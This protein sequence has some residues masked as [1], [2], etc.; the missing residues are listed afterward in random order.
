[1]TTTFMVMTSGL[2]E[3]SSSSF[4][5]IAMASRARSVKCTWNPARATG[6]CC[7]TSGMS[8]ASVS[9]SARRRHCS[10]L[11]RPS[12]VVTVMMVMAISISDICSEDARYKISCGRGWWSTSVLERRSISADESCNVGLLPRGEWAQVQHPQSMSCVISLVCRQLCSNLA[13]QEPLLRTR[14]NMVAGALDLLRRRGLGKVEAR[15]LSSRNPGAH[16]GI[17]SP[18]ADCSFFE[19]AVASAEEVGQPLAPC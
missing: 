11:S 9:V 6:E 2:G 5:P 7:P 14:R 3:E 17:I 15:A 8:T 1:M 16:C 18:V 10:L 4:P 12:G 13:K 19:E